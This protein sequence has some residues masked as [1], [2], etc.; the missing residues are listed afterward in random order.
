MSSRDRVTDADENF[1]H[2]PGNRTGYLDDSLF[3]FDLQKCI[4]CDNFVSCGDAPFHHLDFVAAVPYFRKFDC[5]FHEDAP[6]VSVH[7]WSNMA[8]GCGSGAA[9]VRAITFA[10]SFVI[11]SRARLRSSPVAEPVDSNTCS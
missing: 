8:E 6:T 9:L 4:S 1:D 10:I 3:G 11:S 2:Y 7:T 5:R